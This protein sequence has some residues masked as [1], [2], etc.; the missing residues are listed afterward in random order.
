MRFNTCE[1]INASVIDSMQRMQL[2]TMLVT[3]IPRVLPP[4]LSWRCR[5]SH[6]KLMTSALPL[7][8]WRCRAPQLVGAFF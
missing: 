8:A 7:A 3:E 2:Y 4:S 6:A 5:A 1:F